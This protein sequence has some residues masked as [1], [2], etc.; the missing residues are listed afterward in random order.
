MDRKK[1]II[2]G[3]KNSAEDKPSQIIP[4][5][6]PRLSLKYLAIEVDAVWDIKPWPDNLSKK[7][8]NSKNQV[9]FTLKFREDSI[10]LDPRNKDL[11]ARL[12]INLEKNLTFRR[13]VNHHGCKNLKT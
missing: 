9:G 12:I 2:T 1:I 10:A 5:A 6:F 7:I 13:Q 4:K 3:N 11:G 8:P